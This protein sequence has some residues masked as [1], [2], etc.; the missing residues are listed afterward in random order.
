MIT[1]VQRLMITNM[2]NTELKNIDNTV[3]CED[4]LIALKQ[5]LNI[6]NVSNL[7]LCG[8]CD[9]ETEHE[10]ISSTALKCLDCG[11]IAVE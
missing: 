11:N 8:M 10:Q 4:E 1:E 6:Q 3:Y 7:L 9:K 5:A 2:V